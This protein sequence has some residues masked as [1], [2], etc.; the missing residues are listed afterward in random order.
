MYLVS[1]RSLNFCH[2]DDS[3]YQEKKKKKLVKSQTKKHF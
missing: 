3:F 2:A 1:Y